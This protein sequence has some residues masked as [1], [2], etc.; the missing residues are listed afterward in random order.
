MP[1]GRHWPRRAPKGDYS[2][3]CDVCGVLWRRSQ[4]ERKAD[5]TLCCPDDAAGRDIVTLNE[6]NAR[7]AA[8]L[9]PTPRVYSGGSIHQS[10][11]SDVTDVAETVGN[12]TFGRQGFGGG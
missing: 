12:V 1:V 4:L 8:A 2:A 3:E 6:G 11:Y 7:A 9:G 10:D 5:G